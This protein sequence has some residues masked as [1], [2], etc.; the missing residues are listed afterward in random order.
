MLCLCST[1]RLKSKHTGKYLAEEIAVC[2]QC[3][4]IHDLVRYLLMLERTSL[5][6]NASCFRL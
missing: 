5:I 2:L 6:Y 4:G 1:L 3:Y